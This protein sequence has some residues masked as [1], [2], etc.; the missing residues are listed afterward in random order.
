M[1]RRFQT[2]PR[3]DQHFDNPTKFIKPGVRLGEPIHVRSYLFK[4]CAPP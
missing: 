1:V 4:P 2:K 3:L